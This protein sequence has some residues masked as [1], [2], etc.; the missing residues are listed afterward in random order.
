MITVLKK[1]INMQMSYMLRSKSTIFISLV[2]LTAI[3]IN[4]L[5]NLDKNSEVLYIT[6]MYSF[7]KMLTLSDWTMVGYF[8]MQYYPLLIVIPTACTY[9]ADKNSGVN[10]YIQS[11][12]GKRYYWYGKL[13]SVFVVTLLVFTVPYLIEIALSI[14]C[15][16][17][18]SNGDPSGLAFW[19][20]IETE[21]KYFMS[22]I[23]LDNRIIYVLIMVLLFGI[24]SAVIA[25]FNFAITTLPIFKIKLLTYLPVYILFFAISI[26]SKIINLN[27]TVDYHF[28][29]RMFESS[30]MK[31][32]V[33]YLLFLLL[34]IL[35]S[36]GL[37]EWK[38]KKEELLQ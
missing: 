10:T 29:L 36:V 21:S 1:S 27:F 19:Q 5:V 11:R 34:L 26:V 12:V 15:F 14:I 35:L 20:T 30:T 28:I 6:E 24:V 3:S 4:F 31:N 33:V 2:L 13:I 18:D 16:S 17:L 7:E 8:M 32:Y 22:N 25:T 9:I 23:L 37:I 38:I